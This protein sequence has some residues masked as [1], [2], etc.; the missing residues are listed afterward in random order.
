MQLAFSS[1]LTIDK[2][3]SA[4][5]VLLRNSP[6]KKNTESSLKFADTG[7]LHESG[8]SE[9]EGTSHAHVQVEQDQAILQ[10]PN[11]SDSGASFSALPL[12]TPA[13][14]EK[15]EDHSPIRRVRGLTP[16]SASATEESTPLSPLE[17]LG[18]PDAE[19]EQFL[20]RPK[21]REQ[22]KNE[23]QRLTI[24]ERRLRSTTSHL[25]HHVKIQQVLMRKTELLRNKWG[26]QC[27]CFAA[28]VNTLPEDVKAEALRTS[29][30]ADD[31]N[32]APMAED[33]RRREDLHKLLE[34]EASE[35][36]STSEGGSNV[37]E[38]AI[39][40]DGAIRT[41]SPV[42]QRIGL[43]IEQRMP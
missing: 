14:K 5:M 21:T 35:D 7:E 23:I 36:E 4:C 43:P 26:L 3:L 22:L 24:S 17:D 29:T 18:Y 11:G 15:V 20:N 40:E 9:Q 12:P 34:G 25:E 13:G 16:P 28:F 39:A 37:S 27:N 31:L 2:D 1:P 41:P 42:E 38:K 8:E 30:H 32:R 6:M 10:M 19:L 33:K